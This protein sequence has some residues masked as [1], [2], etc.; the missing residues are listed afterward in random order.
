VTAAAATALAVP[1]G[2]RGDQQVDFIFSAHVAYHHDGAV[3]K[4]EPL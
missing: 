1:T 3:V 4:A 2:G